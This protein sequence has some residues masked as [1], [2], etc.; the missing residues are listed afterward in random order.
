VT[1]R[2]LA[3]ICVVLL[4][5]VL[6]AGLKPFGIPAN[7]V[8]WVSN[9]NAIRFG[10]SGTI[11]SSASFPP[12]GSSNDERSLEIWMQPA[13]ARDS[14]TFAAFYDPAKPRQLWLR[15]SERDLELRIE[16]SAAWRH[17]TT[18]KTYVDNAFRNRA[19][20]FWTITSG[21]MG[22]T[23][24]RDGA[25][26]KESR[27]LL[28]SKDEFSGRLVIGGSPIFNDSWSGVLRGIAIYDHALTAAQIERHY[29]T[30]TKET[31]PKLAADD[32][33]VALYLFDERSGPVIHNKIGSGND[34]YIPE[35]YLVL[36]Q[37]V[38]DPIWRAF[39]W[40]MGFWTD[41]FVNL[42]GFIPVGF[43]FCAYLSAAGFGQ[44]ALAASFAGGAISTF[45][46]LVQCYLPTRD[47]SM[48]DLILNTAGSVIGAGLYR[49]TLE[50]LTKRWITWII[51]I[52]AL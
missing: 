3:A 48:S 24:Y 38:L 20:G 43:F 4:C 35:K 37:T 36:N 32:A 14:N 16:S 30:W 22:T 23:I 50:R 13:L 9:A 44:P 2:L 46:E 25:K 51:Q 52:I 18:A 49:G 27:K 21:S 17:E 26:V 15:Q 7:E 33:C 42:G 28:I 31:R 41:A 8:T 47:S 39:R 19:N 29:R 40:S 1:K 12:T 45:I 5:V 10:R 6:Y 11:L 34:L